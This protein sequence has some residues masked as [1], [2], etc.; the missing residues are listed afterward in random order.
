ME[1]GSATG[2]TG[3][4]SRSSPRSPTPF[5]ANN[6]SRPRTGIRRPSFICPGFALGGVGSSDGGLLFAR[7]HQVSTGKRSS[8]MPAPVRRSEGPEE[9]QG[10]RPHVD[11]EVGH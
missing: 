3:R 7:E 10:G 2:G 11:E 4:Y 6:D 8:L 1:D 5:R 9:R